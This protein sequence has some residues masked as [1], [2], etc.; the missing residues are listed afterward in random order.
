[1]DLRD[2]R[3]RTAALLQWADTAVAIDCGPDF[4]QQMLAA[5]AQ[6][7]DAIVMTHEHNDH[8]I[9]LDDVRPFNF[10]QGG[11]MPVFASEKVQKELKTRFAYVF[12]EGDKRYPGAP[13]VSLISIDKNTVFNIKGLTFVPIEVMHGKLP[14]LGFRIGDFAYLTDVLAIEETEIHKLQN[15][16]TLVVNALHHTEHYSHLN[17]T[18]ALALIEQLKPKHSYLTHM[19]H[20]MGK[21]AEINKTLP[22][23]VE[24]G[25][26]GL[27]ISVPMPNV[28]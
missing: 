4:R 17:L 14:I 22:D 27:R 12:T 11:D 3:L 9:G 20:R 13:M 10:K 18:G 6:H 5:N 19:S 23:G 16:H 2:K 1:M 24:L 7:L 25:Y 21:H 15:L 28:P 26:D 8:I